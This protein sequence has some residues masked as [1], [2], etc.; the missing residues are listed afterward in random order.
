MIKKN[1]VIIGNGPSKN[2][3][4]SF[5]KESDPKKFVLGCNIP[6][7]DIKVDATVI[8]DVEI[9]YILK[10]YLKLVTVPVILSNQA[11]SKMEELGIL[12]YFEVLHVFKLKDWYSTGHYAAEYLMENEYEK[13]DLFGFDSFIKDDISSS[14][15][16]YVPKQDTSEMRF[17]KNWR[18][19]WTEFASDNQHIEFTFHYISK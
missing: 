4:K 13:I 14:T 18:K 2:V 17:I 5:S 10:N 11:Y 15:D 9:I 7:A 8:A 1:A 19:L 16:E 3:Y 12:K 6:D